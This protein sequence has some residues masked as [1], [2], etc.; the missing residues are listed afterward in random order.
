MQFTCR[1][2]Q[3]VIYKKIQFIR[4]MHL[5]ILDL[6]EGLLGWGRERKARTLNLTEDSKRKCI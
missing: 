1:T 4:F 3:E 5:I 6:K 2:N